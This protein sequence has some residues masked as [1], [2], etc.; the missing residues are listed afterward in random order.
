MQLCVC[1]Y[2]NLCVRGFRERVCVSISE[3]EKSHENLGQEIEYKKKIR[4]LFEESKK[5]RKS[6]YIY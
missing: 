2:E 6:Y 5:K 3:R 1:I 4:W